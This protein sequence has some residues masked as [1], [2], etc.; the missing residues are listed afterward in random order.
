MFEECD[1]IHWLLKKGKIKFT[2]IGDT[3]RR[4]TRVMWARQLD[5]LQ[6][7][8]LQTITRQFT[9]RFCKNKKNWK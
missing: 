6:N 5:F 9:A 2:V 7:T 8:V 3:Q 4:M 1:D